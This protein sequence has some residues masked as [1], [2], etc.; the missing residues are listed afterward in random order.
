[1]MTDVLLFTIFVLLCCVNSA[2]N[3][4]SSVLSQDGI[5]G[6][7]S[8]NSGLVTITLT[9]YSATVT[10]TS[11]GTELK[12]KYPE[13]KHM[14]TVTVESVNVLF[15][16]V[17]TNLSYAEIVTSL[18]INATAVKNLNLKF[19]DI[20]SAALI[21]KHFTGLQIEELSVVNERSR[22]LLEL[23]ADAL[24]PLTKLINILID[25]VSIREIPETVKLNK[26]VLR[27]GRSLSKLGQCSDVQSLSLDAW[28]LFVGPDKWWSSSNCT[29]IRQLKVDDVSLWMIMKLLQV[30][31]E[32][33]TDLSIHN[34]HIVQLM[35]PFTPPLRKLEKLDLSH[36][37]IGA[38]SLFHMSYIEDFVNNKYYNVLSAFGDIRNLRT[39]SLAGTGLE[40]LCF[41]NV[42]M[43]LLEYLNLTHNN[44]TQVKTFQLPASNA[45]RVVIDLKDNPIEEIIFSEEAIVNEDLYEAKI[46]FNINY[47]LWIKTTILMNNKLDCD[48]KHGW[49]AQAL[50][51]HLISVEDAK[52]SDGRSLVEVPPEQLECQK[53]EADECTF[54]KQWGST[55]IVANCSG[56]NLKTLPRRVNLE[57]LY[58]SQNNIKTISQ[59]DLPNTL[60]FLDLRKNRIARL[61]E[62]VSRI[63]FETD[64][65]ILLDDNEIPCDCDNNFFIQQL[66]AHHSQVADYYNL[67]CSNINKTIAVV[68]PNDLCPMNMLPI[69]LS[70]STIV[71]L[72][73]LCIILCRVYGRDVKI[74]LFAHGWCLYFVSEEDVDS[75]RCYDAFISFSH[76]DHEFI[77]DKLL[78]VLEPKYKICI[79]FRDWIVGEWIPTQVQKSV[80]LSKRTIIVLSKNYLDSMWGMFEFRISY[81]SALKEGR[82]RIII[83]VIDDVLHSAVEMDPDLRHFV[84]NNTY[85]A[86]DDPWFWQKL[87]YSLPHNALGK[88]GTVI[89]QLEETITW[90]DSS[91]SCPETIESTVE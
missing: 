51:M 45:E 34:C 91:V 17:P 27:R 64:R 50:R 86:W 42:P 18:N 16:E 5:T 82:S 52:C 47:N 7:F 49:L 71:A 89:L 22:L 75:D 15:C 29:N 14:P 6:N 41:D 36:N 78:T 63:M 26:I 12:N 66:Q 59:K 83:I 9:K 13:L 33:L 88:D 24:T 10:C 62:K 25:R 44:I 81:T 58:A 69:I 19:G 60:Q 11:K 39:F 3:E 68:V 21:R 84:M 40:D 23:S 1:M 37:G 2:K 48:C 80:E 70:V 72:A 30:T 31:Y 56:R 4:R 87:R 32:S 76:H 90:R 73:M 28:E 20:K 77:V 35:S 74:F 57:R 85:L 38:N 79:H 67:T 43:P 8:D 54:R 61:D 65:T 46:Y 53:E 55:G